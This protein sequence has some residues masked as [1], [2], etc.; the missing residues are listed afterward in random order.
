M[1]RRPCYNFLEISKIN[2]NL[3]NSRQPIHR[4]CSR[5]NQSMALKPKV[6]E[7]KR[8]VLQSKITDKRTV[9]DYEIDYYMSGSRKISVDDIQFQAAE[10]SMIFHRPGQKIVGIGNYDMYALSLNF[11]PTLVLTPE[12]Y[13]RDRGGPAQAA[14]SHPLLENLPVH[15]HPHHRHDYVRI[16]ELLLLNSY[17][18]KENRETQEKLL[19]ELFLLLNADLYYISHKMQ[20]RMNTA[21]KDCCLYI[22]NNFEKD[23]TLT[24]LSQMLHLSPNY[25]LKLFKKEMGITP[26]EYLLQIRLDYAR[27][28][29]SETDLNINV[30]ASECGFHDASYFSMFFKKRYGTTPLEYRKRH[31]KSK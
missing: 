1:K 30:L 31:N 28:L 7:M 14:Y 23:I 29:L 17:P 9:L 16:F 4:G 11:D 6:L 13:H 3:V 20:D 24:Q 2:P 21:I 26:K 22:N 8:F 15:F 12:A 18:L 25:F 27:S 5:L 10:G 19:N